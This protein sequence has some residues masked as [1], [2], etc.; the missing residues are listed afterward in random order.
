MT[1]QTYV[2]GM[3]CKCEARSAYECGCDADWTPSEVYHLRNEIVGYK[4]QVAGQAHYIKC[5]LD[6][7][8]ELKERIAEFVK[9]A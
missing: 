3:N 1:D 8:R 9:G 4:A 6:E 2:P 7:V 5:L